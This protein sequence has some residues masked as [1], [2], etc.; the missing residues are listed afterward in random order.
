MLLCGEAF[1]RAV[2]MTAG[3]KTF[4]P[5]MSRAG[6]S[7]GP[8]VGSG[9]RCS[10]IARTTPYLADAGVMFARSSIGTSCLSLSIDRARPIGFCQLTGSIRSA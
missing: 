8:I 4:L 2:R 9:K 7:S 5:K 6:G 10:E 1:G 3:L